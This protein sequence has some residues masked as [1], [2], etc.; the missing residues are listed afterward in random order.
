MRNI[1]LVMALAALT[2]GGLLSSAEDARATSLDTGNVSAYATQG[3]LGVD[4]PERYDV[5]FRQASLREALQF[6]AWVADINIMIPEGL[7][8][9]VNVN[10]SNLSIGAA[11]NTIIRANALEYTIEGSVMRIGKEAAF[12]ESGED[13]KTHTFR[14]RF[15]P[16]VRMAQQV[17]QLLSGRG[18]VIADERTNSVIVREL[19]SNIDNVMRFVRDVDLKDTQVLIE[20]KILEATR[21]FGRA[22][23][24]QWGVTRGAAGDRVTVAGFTS[25]ASQSSTG[26]TATGGSSQLNGRDVNVNLPAN[27]PTSGLL[28]GALLGGTNIDVQLLAA[29]QRGDAYII[30]DPSIVTSNGNRA[31]IRSGATLLIQSSGDINI[32]SGSGSGTSGGAGLQEIET[33]IELTVTPQ[34]TMGDY[35]KLDIKAETSQPDFSRAVQ[36]IPVIIDN[37]ATTEVLV[38]NGETTVIGGLSRFSDSTN[39]K[40]V[41]LMHRIPIIGNLFKSKDRRLENGELMVFIKPTII[42]QEGIRPAQARVRD[43]ERRQESMYLAPMSDPQQEAQKKIRKTKRASGSKR[44]KY[45]R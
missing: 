36:G 12:K 39:K 33:G 34:I 3:L 35:V 37:T 4:D 38:K 25:S 11:L 40:R 9:V 19:P 27:S 23:G 45:S 1:V 15:A 2:V 32:G 20:S 16:A 13:L 6:L 21:A 29:E 7:E 42:R 31:K 8:G 26:G 22:L 30:S 5:T 17:K 43:V 41:P 18:A 14:L 44:N 28:L 10:F 24:I